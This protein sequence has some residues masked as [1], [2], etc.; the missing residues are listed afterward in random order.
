M[1]S[2][3]R[4]FVGV[5]GLWHLGCVY[6]ASF[7]KQGYKVTGFDFDKKIVNNLKK[8]IAPIYEPNLGEII[9][10]HNHK[11]LHFTNFEKEAIENMDYIFITFDVPV[12]EHDIIQMKIIKKTFAKLSK[13]LSEETIIVISSQIPV[14][15][16]RILINLLKKRNFQNPRVIYFPENLRLGQAFNSFLKP[17]RIILGAD[18]IET[19]NNFK[20]DFAFFKYPV[21]GM[22]LESAEMVKHALN[23]YL[24]TCIS[25]SSEISDLAEKVGANMMDVVKALKTD[26]RV[27]PFAPINPGLGFAGG[28]LGRDIQTLKRIAKDKKYKTKLLNAIYSVNQDR[29]PMLL[30]KIITIYPS[31]KGMN[32][33]IL[34]LTY[35]PN[36]D[37]L[38]RSQALE[39][40]VLLK[41]KGCRI[42]AFDPAIKNKITDHPFIEVCSSLKTFFKDLDLIILMTEWPQFEGSKLLFLS[43]LMRKKAVVDTKN[44]LDLNLYKKNG[45]TYLGMGVS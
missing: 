27:S 44:F 28:T 31:L 32:V 38:R 18:N 17:D 35:K 2:S 39:L 12:N 16:S 14:G 25:F 10:K 20:K 8:N 40:A 4:L 23:T 19:I 37:T 5:L 21:I 29:V 7:A 42:K 22:G 15:T 1:K 43:D 9:K 36:T 26:K 45:F 11:N 34:G 6:S 13:Y 41:Q 30:G 24:A 3:K 33:G